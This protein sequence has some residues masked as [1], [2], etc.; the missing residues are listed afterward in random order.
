MTRKISHVARVRYSH[1][2]LMK[3][4]VELTGATEEEY[5]WFKYQC[6]LRY[7][8]NILKDVAGDNITSAEIEASY[9]YR[10]MEA[11]RAFW[12]WWKNQW[13]ERDEDFIAEA[14]A[15]F[16]PREIVHAN[17]LQGYTAGANKRMINDAY[18]QL[19]CPYTL[20]KAITP[21][22]AVLEASY[23]RDLVPSI[24]KGA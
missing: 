19:H 7:L 18:A 10:Q 9:D 2:E 6:G 22:G 14:D 11:S 4:V 17:G 21:N 20:A 15:A 13:A 24:N 12:G 5:C 8:I 23:A 1:A 3:R 16:A